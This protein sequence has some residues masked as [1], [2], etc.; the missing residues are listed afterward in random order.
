MK[1]QSSL[2]TDVLLVVK[3]T[4]GSCRDLRKLHVLR[5]LGQKR[6]R[7]YLYISQGRSDLYC[8]QY[9]HFPKCTDVPLSSISYHFPWDTELDCRSSFQNDPYF[10]RRQ[11]WCWCF[12]LRL[13]PRL[14]TSYQCHALEQE[15]GIK[16][17]AV[18]Y[19]G[20][21]ALSAF[22]QQQ[23]SPTGYCTANAVKVVSFFLTS[24][25]F[26]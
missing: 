24:T 22:M 17:A 13:H 25:M 11:C 6:I 8:F 20:L 12:S 18:G 1:H 23:Y 26:I 15:L 3:I 19:N 2:S 9:R 21:A 10:P 4:H 5:K 14:I 7:I 16:S